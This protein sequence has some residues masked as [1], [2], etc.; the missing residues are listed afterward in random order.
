MINPNVYPAVSMEYAEAVK[1]EIEKEG[2]EVA[3]RPCL[4][5][6]GISYMGITMR[7]KEQF[8]PMF[9]LEHVLALLK[10]GNKDISAAFDDFS[11][12]FFAVVS[13][14]DPSNG[15][16]L[17]D[18]IPAASDVGRIIVDNYK[19]FRENVSSLSPEEAN[20]LNELKEETRRILSDYD[21]MRT[22]VF[23]SLINYEWNREYLKNVPHRRFLDLAITYR[24]L[25]VT[26][27]EAQEADASLSIRIT[28]GSLGNMDNPPTEGDLYETALVN[29]RR[30]GYKVNSLLKTIENGM[31]KYGIDPG[32]E[33]RDCI[34]NH[35]APSITVVTT[36]LPDFGAYALI[37]N[38]LLDS[39]ADKAGSDLL[40][41]PSSVSEI[42]VV[43]GTYD[44][45]LYNRSNSGIDRRDLSPTI[46]WLK[47]MVQTGNV[48]SLSMED[49]LS[50]KAYIFERGRGIRI[51]E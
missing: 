7:E 3:I 22:H 34:K 15:S 50:D 6:N 36:P 11:S 18:T 27:E 45:K 43:D 20:N 48:K 49:N 29:I 44:P 24:V 14:N 1:K 4:K 37:D 41:I 31:K 5:N 32:E 26:D 47:E 46:A 40:I 42:L 51:A 38:E 12:G 35:D 23:P 28:N 10:D 9:Y 25:L 2:Y 30:R 19:R 16:I 8:S 33:I 39:L 13:Q 21:A 17:L